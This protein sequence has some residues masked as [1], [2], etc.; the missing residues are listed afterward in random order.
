M[1]RV[2]NDQGV[3]VHP[4]DKV[5]DKEG[6]YAT[7]LN[8]LYDEVDSKPKEVVEQWEH[9]RSPKHLAHFGL[10]LVDEEQTV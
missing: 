7:L 4:G 8:V 10:H 2:V 1:L 3:E 9:K 6:N 5:Y